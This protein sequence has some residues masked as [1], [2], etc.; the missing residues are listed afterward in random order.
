MI[1]ATRH[2]KADAWILFDVYVLHKKGSSAY[3]V[4]QPIPLNIC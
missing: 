3:S 1:I 4:V 2:C